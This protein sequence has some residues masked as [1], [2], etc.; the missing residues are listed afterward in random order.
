MWLKGTVIHKNEANVPVT[1]YELKVKLHLVILKILLA[2]TRK[3]GIRYTRVSWECTRA[4]STFSTFKKSSA[5]TVL[6]SADFIAAIS[7]GRMQISTKG[8]DISNTLAVKLVTL[9]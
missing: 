8:R 3:F 5:N 7:T 9:H 2:N 1:M 6:E 4:R